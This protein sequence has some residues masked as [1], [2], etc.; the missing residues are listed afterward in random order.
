MKRE[1]AN[2]FQGLIVLSA[3]LPERVR[4]QTGNAQ[5]SLQQAHQVVLSSIL[6]PDFCL[7]SSYKKK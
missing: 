1:P 7:L 2:P 4:S 5:V 6:A 3:C